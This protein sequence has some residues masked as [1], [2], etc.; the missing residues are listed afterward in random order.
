MTF[1]LPVHNVTNRHTC[2]AEGGG[3]DFALPEGRGGE[4][5]G[6]GASR[7]GAGDQGRPRGGKK[8]R[9]GLE[10]SVCGRRGWYNVLP[11]HIHILPRL[12]QY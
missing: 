11:P 9:V 8:V 5:G 7:E 2:M 10:A 1:D 12:C 6:K 4:A 3:E